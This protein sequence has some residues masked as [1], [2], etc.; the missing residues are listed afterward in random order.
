MNRRDFLKSAVITG[1]ALTIPAGL[2]PF[3]KTMD[4]AEKTD[5]AVVHGLPN[6]HRLSVPVE[7]RWA[8]FPLPKRGRRP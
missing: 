6:P 1:A 2:D 3:L 7:V 4:A 5:L 8:R